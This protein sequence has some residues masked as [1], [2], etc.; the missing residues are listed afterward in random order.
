MTSRKG[1]GGEYE[2]TRAAYD[3]L[4][5]A[6]KRLKVKFGCVLLP[7]EVKGIWQLVVQAYPMEGLHQEHPICSYSATWPNSVS[8]TFA[9]FLYG[10]THRVVRMA[11][12]WA[13]QETIAREASSN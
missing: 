1:D 4:K 13:V 9:A 3:E 8:Q 10:A 5:D 6:E 11:E 12:A 7:G 2:F